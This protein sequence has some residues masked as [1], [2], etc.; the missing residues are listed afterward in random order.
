MLVTAVSHVEVSFKNSVEPLAVGGA[1]TEPGDAVE[2]DEPKTA[3]CKSHGMISRK[4]GTAVLGVNPLNSPIHARPE[5][6]LPGTV[7]LRVSAPPA[8]LTAI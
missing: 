2:P 7:Q 3:N 4:V 5:S 1:G 8:M 6:M